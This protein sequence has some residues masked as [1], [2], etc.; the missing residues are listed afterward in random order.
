[1]KVLQLGKFYPI[2]GGVEKVMFDLT[3]GLSEDGVDCDMLC[4]ISKDRFNAAVPGCGARAAV[5]EV[6]PAAGETARAGQGPEPST[7]EAA[8]TSHSPEDVRFN[9]DPLHPD[10]IL[11]AVL[12]PHS[13]LICCK[14]LTKK[15]ATMLSPAMIRT[16][17]RICNDYDIIHIH[18]PDP[19]AALALLLSGYKGRVILHWHSDI[20]K[21]KLL[22][23]F[24]RPLQNWLTSRAETI[25]GTSPVYVEESPHLRHCK[26]KLTYLPIGVPQMRPDPEKVREIRNRFPGKKIILST[27]RLVE[28]KGFEYLIDA[29]SMLDDGHV[30]LIGGTGP[31]ETALK[32]RIREGG[33][34][35]KVFLE[36]W[37]PT[38]WI[39]SYFG[40]C[41]AF[42]LSSIYKTEAFGIVQIEAMSVGKPVVATRIP[43]SG[44]AWVNKDGVSGL[45]VP[46][47]YPAALAEALKKVTDDPETNRRLGEGAL[48]RYES[49]FTR[50]AMIDNCKRIYN[51]QK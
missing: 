38:G 17:R 30:V 21:Q 51:S 25:V 44:V 29:A 24:Y 10:T 9:A 37:I 3:T 31:L 15:A 13:R 12:N 46:P 34:D 27:G 11:T 16:L 18:H 48:K 2:I 33:L 8:G 39:S 14:A 5:A 43:E 1:L 41:D 26:D 22:F 4:A 23:Q 45:N 35:G 32:Q 42:C 19:M 50:K 40:A 49:I 36:G 20:L 28:Y 47:A 6:A 7:P